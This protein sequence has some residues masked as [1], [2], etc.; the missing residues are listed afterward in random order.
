MPKHPN[1]P[2]H[3]SQASRWPRSGRLRLPQLRFS[4]WGPHYVDPLGWRTRPWPQARTRLY[5]TY[6]LVAVALVAL[7][8]GCVGLVTLA[9][10]LLVPG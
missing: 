8:F 6:V 1:H 2:H 9:H 4:V 7:V 10:W 5:G 3:H